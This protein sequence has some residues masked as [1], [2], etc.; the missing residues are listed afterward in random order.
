MTRHGL[1]WTPPGLLKLEQGAHLAAKA[2]PGGFQ[3]GCGDCVETL[4]WLLAA[5][6]DKE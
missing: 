6:P 3:N 5:E 2:L 4:V 1:A